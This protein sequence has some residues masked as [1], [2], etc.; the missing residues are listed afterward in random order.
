MWSSS[1]LS[2][3]SES[4]PSPAAEPVRAPSISGNTLAIGISSKAPRAMRSSNG[5]PE[6]ENDG[7]GAKAPARWAVGEEMDRVVPK[8]C[9]ICVLS[10]SPSVSIGSCRYAC[11]PSL[12]ETTMANCV[13]ASGGDKEAMSSTVDCDAVSGSSSSSSL[14]AR[15][16][17]GESVAD[18][19]GR[20]GESLRGCEDWREGVVDEVEELGECKASLLSNDKYGRCEILNGVKSRTI[21]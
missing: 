11:K 17:S 9:S 10:H 16:C 14:R 8:Y 18:A 12:P 7:G 20:D 19:A 15:R 1:S 21:R 13:H 2:S 5:V 3:V 4:E 6:G